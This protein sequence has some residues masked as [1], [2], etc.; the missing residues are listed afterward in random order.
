MQV[1]SGL[2]DFAGV[3][4]SQVLVIILKTTGIN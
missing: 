2:I 4:K 1:I 3:S